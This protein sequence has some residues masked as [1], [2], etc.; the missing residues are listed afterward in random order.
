MPEKYAKVIVNPVAG[1]GVTGR[2]WPLIKAQLE[3]NSLGYDLRFTSEKGHATQIARE[4]ADQG[5]SFIIAVGGDGTVNEVANG[6]LTS[7][8]RKQTTLGVINTGT[9]SDYIRTVGTP[10]DPVAACDFLARKDRFLI[11]V[12]LVEYFKDGNRKRRFFINYAGTGFDSEVAEATNRMSKFSFV[13]NTVPYV[14]S[15]LRTLAGYKNKTV[16]LTIDGD[17]RTGRVLSVIIANG[18]YVGGGMKVAPSA[19]L[20]DGKLDVVTINDVGKLELLRAFP[21]IYSG[22]HITHP[23]VDLHL[24]CHVGVEPVERMPVSADGELLGECPATFDIIPQALA[25]AR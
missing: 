22:S 20:C 5:Y 6:I 24:A 25:V 1:R 18:R 11:D 14:L 23:K 10:R 3:A 4:A 13:S 8:N 2:K 21:R 19:E 15:L 16:N 7:H 17:T 12:G 9:G